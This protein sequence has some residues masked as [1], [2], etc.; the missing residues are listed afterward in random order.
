MGKDRNILEFK[1][2]KEMLDLLQTDTDL[3]NLQTGDYVFRYNE[4]GSI[5]VYSLSLKEAEQLQAKAE[6]EDEYWGAYLGFG[7]SIYDVPESD[8]YSNKQASA[9][10]YC[11]EMYDE[12]EWIRCY[13][14]SLKE[15]V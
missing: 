14:I 4:A 5:A 7:G 3:Y 10:D 12:G 1:S 15:A 8:F 13:D 2:G 9:L 11:S 6:A